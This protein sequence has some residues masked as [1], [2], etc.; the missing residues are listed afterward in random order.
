MKYVLRPVAKKNSLIYRC[1]DSKVRTGVVSLIAP[2]GPVSAPE[3]GQAQ[4]RGY[5]GWK[6][7]YMNW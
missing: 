4:T 3:Y 5:E 6:C 1:M 2:A 7:L